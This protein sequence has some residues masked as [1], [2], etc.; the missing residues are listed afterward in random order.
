M[1]PSSKAS[2]K[3]CGMRSKVVPRMSWC[4]RASMRARAPADASARDRRDFAGRGV[5]RVEHDVVVVT[6]L[7]D[8][9]IGERLM[10]GAALRRREVAAAHHGA[11]VDLGELG[12]DLLL[13]VAA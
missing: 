7:E 6:P 12:R 3:S 13:V 2:T 9:E 4:G 8:D 5:G 10:L 11:D 1:P